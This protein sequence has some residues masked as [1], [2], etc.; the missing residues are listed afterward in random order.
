MPLLLLL[1]LL[2]AVE[3]INLLQMA[4]P[5]GLHCTPP[6]F[7]ALH[8]TSLHLPP[9]GPGESWSVARVS[10]VEGGQ[11]SLPCPLQVGVEDRPART[12]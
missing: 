2:A 8:C 3:G 4:G 6:P 5:T 12:N 1:L 10:A 7:T 11:A 9:D